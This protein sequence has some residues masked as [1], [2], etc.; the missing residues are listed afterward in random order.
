MQGLAGTI[1]PIATGRVLITISGTIIATANTIND[2]IL[3]QISHGTGTAPINAAA[4][5]GTQVGVIQ[6]YTNP[7]AVTAADVH[8]PFSISVVVSGLSL[9]VAHWIDLAA[10]SVTAASAIALTSVSITA[11][12]I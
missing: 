2:G 10:K 1:T 12:E 6:E 9:S 5:T 11:V 8:V 4:L 7:V 3:Y